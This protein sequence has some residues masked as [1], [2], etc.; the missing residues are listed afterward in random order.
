MNSNDQTIQ[1]QTKVKSVVN[2]QSCLTK[3]LS[4]F[5]WKYYQISNNSMAKALLIIKLQQINVTHFFIF[6]PQQKYSTIRISVPRA[7]RA[8]LV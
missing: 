7:E 2:F 6:Y 5:S 4:K 3:A 8:I 1:N